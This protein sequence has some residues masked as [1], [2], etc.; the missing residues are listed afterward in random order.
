MKALVYTNTRTVEYQEQSDPVIRDGEVRVNITAVGICG[1]DMHAYLGHNPRR[2]R[3]PV[4]LACSRFWRWLRSVFHT[5][6]WPKP[7]TCAARKRRR[8]RIAGSLT[9]SPH[10]CGNPPS[11]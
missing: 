4:Q 5:L 9:Q 1:S 3:E 6:R 2:V 8:H 7:M 10:H 11:I